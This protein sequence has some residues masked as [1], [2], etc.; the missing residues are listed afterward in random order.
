MQCDWCSSCDGS[1]DF[2]Y[3]GSVIA[4]SEGSWW[5][6]FPWRGG[7]GGRPI[8]ILADD[9]PED[10]LRE[11]CVAAQV[12]IVA[13]GHGIDGSLIGVI[14]E[15]TTAVAASPIRRLEAKGEDWRASG[16]AGTRRLRVPK[17]VS[18]E[19]QT[20]QTAPAWMW[21]ASDADEPSW[22]F[23][24]ALGFLAPRI[25]ARGPR[26]WRKAHEK[27]LGNADAF[28]NPYNFVPLGQG[29]AR[30]EP[31]GHL[32]LADN[33]VSGHVDVR[34]TAHTALALSGS[35]T[36][37]DP[38]HA[39][40]PIV[41][42][43]KHALA[44]SQLAGAVRAYHEA[45]TDSCLRVLDVEYVPV[46]RDLALPQKPGRWRMAVV[47][48]ETGDEVRL[49]EPVLH[50]DQE[51]GAF[52]IE[53]RQL[54]DGDID[55]SQRFHFD[56]AKAT[57]KYLGSRS[58]L[59]WDAGS[60]PERCTAPEGKCEESHWRTIVTEALPSRKP[61]PATNN[62][63]PYHLPFARLSADRLPIGTARSVYQQSAHDA[64][65]VVKRRRNE[66]PQ[67]GVPGVGTRQETT[68]NLEQGQVVWVELDDG[69]VVRVSRSVLWRSPGAGEVKDRIGASS[70]SGDSAVGY[71]PCS[72]PEDLCPS[73]QLFGMVEERTGKSSDRA[74]VAAYRGHVRFSH[75]VVSDVDPTS[76]HIRELG[77]PRPSAGQFYL[78]NNKWA[79]KQA[80]K[81]ERPLRE[82]GSAADRPTPRQIAGRKFYWT[83]GPGDRHVADH[84]PHA[85]MTSHHRLT[86]PGAT[87]TFRVWFDNVTPTQ[88]GSLLVSLDPNLLRHADLRERLTAGQGESA[89]GAA[90]ESALGLHLGK[91]KGVGLG[92]VIPC[93]ATYDEDGKPAWSTTDDH[94]QAAVVTSGVERYLTPG[95]SDQVLSVQPCVEQFVDE[96]INAES[97]ARWSALLAMSAIDWLP[98]NVV[99]YPPDNVPGDKFQ[100]DFWQLSSGAPGTRKVKFGNST[101]PSTK[102]VLVTLPA[103]DAVDATVK[104]PWLED[105]H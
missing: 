89:I 54:I 44:G 2:Y 41:M 81:D 83:T 60:V 66:Q 96:T 18:A 80:G 43:G 17:E 7:L 55:S 23:E 90:L 58:R 93:L 94:S 88:L 64:G 87:V 82:W 5:V 19:A 72:G 35:G 86:P 21:D 74:R 37:R 15:S 20:L 10:W 29:P 104:R 11:P 70:H 13:D 76:V 100:F 24:D 38:E 95:Q 99:D 25:A 102:P 69:E 22:Q 65:D 12:E 92:A 73:C 68:K 1:G 14:V 71:A 8:R 77:T 50:D 61:N 53:V 105:G 6:A 45:L 62:Q 79:G 36:G 27:P 16:A 57:I 52:W 103:P 91:G 51:Y 33:R 9:L 84:N 49:C 97:R 4:R 59:E 75:A 31:T 30:D 40:A 42:G 28:V 67:L 32:E 101:G 78:Q 34:W 39:Y 98:A 3:R 47:D 48:G 56:R 63:H 85:L 26:R 46:H